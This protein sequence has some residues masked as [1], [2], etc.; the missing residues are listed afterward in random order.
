MTRPP[1]EEDRVP[2]ARTIY[3]HPNDHYVV[4]LIVSYSD[5][6]SEGVAAGFGEDIEEGIAL[7]LAAAQQARSGCF[8]SRRGAHRG[9]PRGC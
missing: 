4:S 3:D 9:N 5:A 6:V 7:D 8:T 1:F 2:E